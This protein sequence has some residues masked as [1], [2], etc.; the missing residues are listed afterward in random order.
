MEDLSPHF[1]QKEFECR[2]CGRLELHPKLLDEA[3]HNVAGVPVITHAGYRC[4]HP[5]LG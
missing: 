5:N 4:P 3:L 1:S 2:C